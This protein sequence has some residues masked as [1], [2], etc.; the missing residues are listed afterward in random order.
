M[1]EVKGPVSYIVR[2]FENGELWHRHLNQIQDREAD[3]SSQPIPA[4]PSQTS[5]LV[6][7]PVTATTDGNQPQPQTELAR[8]ETPSMDSRTTPP[9]TS[10]TATPK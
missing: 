6:G 4:Q 3:T 10:S 7:L 5:D 8:R 2:I 1:E 9:T